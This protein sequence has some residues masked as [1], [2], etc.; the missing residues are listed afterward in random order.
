MFMNV[1][2]SK[3]FEASFCSIGARHHIS[4]VAHVLELAACTERA[5][6]NSTTSKQVTLNLALVHYWQDDGLGW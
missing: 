3:Y 2:S 6:I 4:L 5:Q 1:H